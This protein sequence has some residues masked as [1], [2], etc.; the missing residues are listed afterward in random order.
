MKMPEMSPEE[1]LKESTSIEVLE[2]EIAKKAELSQKEKH[3]QQQAKDIAYTINH[4]LAC[5]AVDWLGQTPAM[6]AIQKAF[7]I[8]NPTHIGCSNPFHKHEDGSSCGHHHH[9]HDHHHHGHDH[10]H[11]DTGMS[12]SEKALHAKH[13]TALARM[14]TASEIIGDFGGVIPTVLMQRYT[15]WAMDGIRPVLRA[16]LGPVFHWGAEQSTKKW[17]RQQGIEAGSNEYKEHLNDIYE[18]EMHHLPQAAWWTVWS[19][20]F[21]VGLQK[22]FYRYMATPQIRHEFPLGNLRQLILTKLGG[23][24]LSIGLVLGTRAIFPET[25]HRFT[26]WTEENFVTPTTKVVTRTLGF[27]DKAVDEAI[28]EKK[29]YH[30]GSLAKEVEGKPEQEPNRWE[31]KIEQHK[32]HSESVIAA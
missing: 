21:N 14:Y 10:H 28:A 18:H 16:T 12:A 27:D 7:G 9:G 15:P 2:P 24:S 22:P 19:S 25:A 8:R 4:A 23:A 1:N 5:T 32:R 26:N 6:I 20:A 13:V 31:E 30:D 17:A 11:H 29:Y 3:D